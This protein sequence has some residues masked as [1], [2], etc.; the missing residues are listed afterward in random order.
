[1]AIQHCSLRRIRITLVIF[2]R[3]LPS[4]VRKILSHLIRVRNG[5]AV[6]IDAVQ[7]VVQYTIEI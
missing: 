6:G 3:V 7:C 5:S 1:M 2:K 4:L